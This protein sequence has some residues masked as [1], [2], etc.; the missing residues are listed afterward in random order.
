MNAAIGA[1]ALKPAI[2]ETFAFADAPKACHAM[3]AAG[4]F[5]KIA[6]AL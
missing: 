1:N 6:I 3:E 5:G 2:D 4:H